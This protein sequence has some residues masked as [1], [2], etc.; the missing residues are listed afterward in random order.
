MIGKRVYLN[1]DG[2]LLLA[3]GEY[4][5]NSLDIWQARPPK[6]HIGSLAE[7]NVVE[8]EDGTITVSPSIL[9]TCGNE[10]W[11]GYLEKGIWRGV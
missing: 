10:R 3:A 5:K 7:H 8:N 6:G 11:H 4:G 2:E 9:V 1:N